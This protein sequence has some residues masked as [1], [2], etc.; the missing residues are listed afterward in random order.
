M[1][2]HQP[3]HA[4]PGA[5]QYITI[6]AILTF[7]TLVEVSVYYIAA[8]R[9]VLLPVLVVLSAGK[10][11]LVVMYYMHLKFDNR[12]FSGMFLFGLATALFTAI[13]FIFLFHLLQPRFVT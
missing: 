2:A 11:A 6:A 13:A 3:E 9:P 8:L 12:L 5:Q 4:H 1:S 7:I 10:F